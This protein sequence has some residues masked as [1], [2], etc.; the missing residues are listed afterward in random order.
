MSVD[1]AVD[2]H[3]GRPGLGDIILDALRAGGKDLDNLTP[4]DLAPVDQFHTRGREATLELL[5]LAEFQAG[6]HVLDVGGG[7]GGPAR[8]LASVAGC[9]VTVLDLTEEFCRVGEMLTA[10][11]GLSGRVTF[12]HG[13][14]LEMPF[15]DASFDG[16]WTQHSSMNIEDKA[17]LYAEMFRVLRP[18]GRLALH[19]IMA[20]E[21]GPIHFPVPWAGEPSISFLRRPD[22][23]RA[24]L[25]ATGFKERAWLDVTAP[26]LEFF[27]RLQARAAAPASG[28]P[29]LGINLQLGPAF[30]EMAANQVRNIREGRV[31]IIQAVFERP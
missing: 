31:A 20:G 11:L 26:A 16:V 12:R 1:R 17:R 21:T 7:I 5:R 30:G 3:Y 19:E 2:A 25:A 22:E 27:D 29:P 15:P 4:D 10:R 14:A 9:R 28:P 18:G 24:L 23:V 8:T 6:M 13:S